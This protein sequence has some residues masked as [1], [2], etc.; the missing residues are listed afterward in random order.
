MGQVLSQTFRTMTGLSS[1]KKYTNVYF[2]FK[3][4]CLKQCFKQ[5]FK[6]RMFF[7][8]T[9]LLQTERGVSPY[10]GKDESPS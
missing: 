1:L 8:Q 9:A 3:N 6:H 7:F 4:N 10:G 2:L 5:C